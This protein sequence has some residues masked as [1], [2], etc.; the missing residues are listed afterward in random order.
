MPE[1]ISVAYI[2]ASQFKSINI[3]KII[4]NKKIIIIQK[5]YKKINTA[6]FRSKVVPKSL[7]TKWPR[8]AIDQ[9]HTLREIPVHDDDIW[10][11]RKITFISTINVFY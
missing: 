2:M 9:L 8:I 6:L 11:Q 5:I 4:I 3:K 7:I 10:T 1:K